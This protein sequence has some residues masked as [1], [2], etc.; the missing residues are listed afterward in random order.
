MKSLS[1]A[2]GFLRKMAMVIRRRDL[3]LAAEFQMLTN[4]GDWISQHSRVAL[5]GKYLS[6]NASIFYFSLL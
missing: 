1:G 2:T 5:L 4:G 3:F 6:I